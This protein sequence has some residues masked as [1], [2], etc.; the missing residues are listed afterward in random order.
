MR[1]KIAQKGRA[2]HIRQSMRPTTP[3]LT[4]HAALVGLLMLLDSKRHELESR[5]QF[6]VA[7]SL[8]C[9]HVRTGPILAVS[10][11]WPDLC[12]LDLSGNSL[13]GEPGQKV[14]TLW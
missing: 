6:R 7:L 9:C 8:P 12:I 11:S 1:T 4:A 5:T 13:E 10:G 3:V 2:A 14:N